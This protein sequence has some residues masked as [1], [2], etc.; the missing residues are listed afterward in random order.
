MIRFTFDE[1]EKTM[2]HKSR[3]NLFMLSVFVS[4]TFLGLTVPSSADSCQP[5]FDAL[6]KVVTTPSHSYTTH[7]AS[8]V[9][10]GKPRE[11]EAIYAQGKVYIR[12]NGKWMHSPVTPAE[13]LEQ[14]KENREHGKATCQ[15]MGNKFVG[16]EAALLYSMHNEN[17]DVR[18]DAQM[19]ISKSTGLPLR[20]EEDVD[21]GGNRVRE[22]RS[23]RFEYTNIGPPL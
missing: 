16:A 6:D 20:N 12:A 19:W 11:S 1:M 23:T 21:N 2:V 7:T 10:G 8:F 13:I 9:N 4:V 15:F 18:E 17:E 14:Q 5:V 22:H 3:S